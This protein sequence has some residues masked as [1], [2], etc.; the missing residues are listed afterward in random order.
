MHSAGAAHAVTC[1]Y[2]FCVGIQRQM[3]QDAAYNVVFN[4]LVCL[5]K[6][7]MHFAALQHQGDVL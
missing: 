4:A 3:L 1:A 5:V 6:P 7:N 2:D